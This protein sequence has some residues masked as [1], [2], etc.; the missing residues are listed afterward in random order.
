LNE[1]NGFVD[2]WAEGGMKGEADGAEGCEAAAAVVP[3]CKMLFEGGDVFEA[4]FAEAKGGVFA[5]KGDVLEV[6]GEA[7]APKGGGLLAKGDVFAAKGEALGV[8]N[9]EVVC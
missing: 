4:A 9:G 8:P 2:G 6:N 1:P 7:L 3:S 5:A